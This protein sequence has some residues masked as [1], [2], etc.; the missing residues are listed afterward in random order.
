MREQTNKDV[1]IGMEALESLLS[2]ISALGTNLRKREPPLSI[3]G[4]K[5]VQELLHINDRL[6]R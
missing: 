3:Y 2:G 1:L 5:Q 6:I 4:N